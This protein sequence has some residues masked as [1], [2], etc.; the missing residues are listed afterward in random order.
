M[1]FSLACFFIAAQLLAP[2]GTPA[3]AEPRELVLVHSGAPG[4]LYEIGANEFARRV[5]ERLPEDY[6]ISVISDPALGDSPALVDAVRSGAAVFALPSSAMISVS[7]AFAV[8][9]LP[10]LIRNRAQ[11][12]T[13]RSALLENYLQPEAAKKGLRILGIWENGFRQFTND[14]R[15]IDRPADLRGMRLAIPPNPWR[16]KA[17]RAFGADPVPMATRAVSDALRTGVVDGYEAPLTEISAQHLTDVQHRLSLS[18]HLYSPA[19]L[20]TS[21]TQFERLPMPIRA[22]IM[23]EARAMEGWISTLA[24]DMES[25]LVDQLDRDMEVT[26]VDTQAFRAA[27]RGVYGEFIRTVP[28]GAKMIEALTDDLAHVSANGAPTD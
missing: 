28:G 23:S 7:D 17:L 26:H 21:R 18:D 8:F 2:A 20:I 9:E 14:V 27:S 12:K 25:E 22:V 3:K 19:F 13:I 5:N 11:V 6:R 24:I 16:E 1:R 15:R 4:S 10:Y